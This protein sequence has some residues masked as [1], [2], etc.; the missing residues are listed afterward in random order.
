MQRPHQADRVIGSGLPSWWTLILAHQYGWDEIL[1]FAVP[2]LLALAGVRWAEKRAKR[3]KD[4]G[5]SED[6]RQTG[7]ASDRGAGD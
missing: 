3:K 4:E 5:D 6:R 7:R 1:L 2:I